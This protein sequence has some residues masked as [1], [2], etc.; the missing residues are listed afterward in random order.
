MWW[1][2][3]WYV[4][5][6]HGQKTIYQFEPAPS[7]VFSKP[8]AQLSTDRWTRTYVKQSA[9]SAPFTTNVRQAASAFE[10]RQPVDPRPTPNNRPQSCIRNHLTGTTL[11][12]RV[13]SHIHSSLAERTSPS[14][15]DETKPTECEY[16]QEDIFTN[17]YTST[18]SKA[19]GSVL[20]SKE[21]LKSF[22]CVLCSKHFPPDATIYPDP[23]YPSTTTR[24]MCKPCFVHN[25]GTK[26]DC[27]EC[28]RPVLTLANEGG[29]VQNAGR[30]WHSLCFRC[31]GCFKD[32]SGSPM[33]DLLGRP[34]CEACFDTCLKRPSSD[35]PRSLRTSKSTDRLDRVSNI[36]G[37]KGTSREASPA[38]EELHQ[39]LGIKSREASPMPERVFRANAQ[40]KD[41]SPSLT[42]LSQRLTG[43]LHDEYPSAGAR[44]AARTSVSGILP[45]STDCSPTR[46]LQSRQ[47]KK[48]SSSTTIDAL[49]S[50]ALV[51]N[52]HTNLQANT[53]VPPFR[54]ISPSISTYSNSP[55]L[56]P[57]TPDL[58]SDF[59][60]SRTMSSA[61]STPSSSSP[62]VVSA[63]QFYPKTPTKTPNKTPTKTSELVGKSA[64]RPLVVDSPNT[65]CAGC[66]KP[67]YRQKNGGKFVTVPEQ[68]SKCVPPKSYHVDCFRCAACNKA[69]EE[70]KGGKTVFV[71]SSS[72]YCHVEVSQKRL[73]PLHIQP[74]LI[75]SLISALRPR[76][77]SSV[78]FRRLN[79]LL[80]SRR[81]LNHRSK[82]PL[83]PVDH[84]LD[85]EV[86]QLALAAVYSSRL[87]NGVSFQVHRV[88]V[89]TQHVWCVGG[90]VQ[91]DDGARRQN[92]D[93]VSVLTVQRGVMGM[94]GY[95]VANAW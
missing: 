67:L 8:E 45:R 53:T 63:M 95:G 78:L 6:N 7:V 18:L 84:S 14:T 25:G 73:I 86:Q 1:D 32:I 50:R 70:A 21:T 17:P 9:P 85:L 56:L 34:S 89:G 82:W 31:D 64:S 26:G 39:R 28:G 15:K 60:D 77:S 83:P 68:S 52:E 47:I 87:W 38:I 65:P 16:L 46:M 43:I 92:Q 19:Y 30:F 20:Q 71:R 36:G 22:A 27:V 81:Q 40:T 51:D 61:P 42:E 5:V 24:F 35:S 49:V 41:A 3:S 91:R 55:N 90:R 80:C 72:G 57:M 75:S 29:F 58:L 13:T 94:A 88:V 10:G 4:L 69:F 33:V 76:G 74:F 62:P 44:R 66:S 79:H 2:S 59:S 37:L 48:Q 12:S 93:A 54:S 11:D 23:A